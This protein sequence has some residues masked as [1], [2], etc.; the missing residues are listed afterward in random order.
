[1]SDL[2]HRY[3]TGMR[4]YTAKWRR[5]NGEALLAT[6]IESAEASGRSRPTAAELRN[7]RGTGSRQRAFTA[8]PFVLFAI[9]ILSALSVGSL[10]LAHVGGSDLVLFHLPAIPPPRVGEAYVVPTL[11]PYAARWEYAVWSV[12]FTVSLALGLLALRRNRRLLTTAS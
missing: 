10:A 12:L 1:M 9:A 8:L 5:H 3:R 11:G 6:L 7:L 4:W 2:E